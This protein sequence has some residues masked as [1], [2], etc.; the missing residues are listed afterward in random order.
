[1]IDEPMS[2]EAVEGLEMHR[3]TLTLSRSHN[4]GSGEC[5]TGHCGIVPRST[6]VINY[7]GLSAPR[8]TSRGA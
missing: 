2:A 7:N 4:S 3:F 1:M 6:V 8:S 5:R